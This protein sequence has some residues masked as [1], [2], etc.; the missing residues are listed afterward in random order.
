MKKALIILIVFAIASIA[1]AALRKQATGERKMFTHGGTE[2][3]YRIY[4]PDAVKESKSLVPLVFNFH[5]GAGTAEVASKMG[6]TPIAERENFIVVYPEGLNKHWNDGRNAQKFAE[7]DAKTD[8]V[9]FVV[10]LLDHLQ[11]GFPQ[12][13]PKRIFTT[14]AS[15]GGFISHRIAIEASDRFA[16]AGIIIAPL[17]KPFATGEK[18]FKPSHPI[19]ILIMNGTADPFVPYDG[20]PITPNFMPMRRK[21]SDVDF[22]RGECSSTDQAIALWLKHN[23]LENKK[24]AIE[25]LPD[26]DPDDECTVEKSTWSGGEN[27]TAVVLYKVKGGGHTVPGGPQYLPKKIIGNTCGDFNGIRAIWE[28]FKTHP[29]VV[30]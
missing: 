11:K 24:P 25:I 19:S 8:D 6:W 14:G 17:P 2:R 26:K 12:I 16:A 23:Q 27:R 7:Q 4:V 28:F 1:F 15:N 29:K 22:G 9:A 5:G 13:D 30:E 18:P 21:S 20:G 3:A 10:A